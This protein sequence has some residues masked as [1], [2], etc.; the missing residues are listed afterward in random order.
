MAS[1]ITSFPIVYLTVYSSVDQRKHQSSAL[2]AFVQGIQRW[3]VNSPHKGPVM[4]KIFP[5]DDIIMRID[6]QHSTLWILQSGQSDNEK[7]YGWNRQDSQSIIF[8]LNI[9]MAYCKTAESPLAIHW[10]YNRMAD[11]CISIAKKLEIQG[12]SLALRCW[13][14]V[15]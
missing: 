11:C 4:Q 7:Q 1:Q 13:Y 5:F 6:I 12:P 10:R 9:P 14:E 15:L 2:L 8:H 3:L